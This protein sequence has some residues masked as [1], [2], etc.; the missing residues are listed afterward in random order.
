MWAKENKLSKFLLRL[1]IVM[2]RFDRRPLKI[3]RLLNHTRSLS[4]DNLF[5]KDPLKITGVKTFG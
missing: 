5:P 1:E 4:G 2:Q 3:E